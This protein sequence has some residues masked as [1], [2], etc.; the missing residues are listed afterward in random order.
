MDTADT[1]TTEKNVS[2]A[3]SLRALRRHND[4]STAATA[5]SKALKIHPELTAYDLKVLLI[6]TTLVRGI[7]NSDAHEAKKIG[8]RRLKYLRYGP[9]LRT[10]DGVRYASLDE[11]PSQNINDMKGSLGQQDGRLIDALAEFIKEIGNIKIYI[12]SAINDTDFKY[13]GAEIT[14]SKRKKYF[15]QL[16]KQCCFLENFPLP[17]KQTVIS[18]ATNADKVQETIIDEPNSSSVPTVATPNTEVSQATMAEAP[19]SHGWG[20][21]G[22]LRPSYTLRQVQGGIL[23][24]T[25][26]FNSISN[27]TMGNEKKFVAVR[28]DDGVHAGLENVWHSNYITVEDGKTYIIRLYVHNNNPNGLQAIA[29]NVRAAFNLPSESGRQIRVTG[30][31]RSSNATP[32]QYWANVVFCSDIVQFHLEYIWGSA[33]LENRGLGQRTSIK[34]SDDIVTRASTGGILV[35]YDTLD[36]SVPGGYQFATYITIRVKA[37]FEADYRVE[38]RVRLAGTDEWRTNVENVNVGDLIEFRIQYRNISNQTQYDVM[39]RDILPKNLV[40]VPDTTVLVN[41]KE[42]RAFNGDQDKLV[43]SGIDI[44]SYLPGANAYVDFTAKVI[45]VTLQNGSNT[46]VNWSQCGVG[47]V[48]LQDYATVQLYIDK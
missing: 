39:L 20:D 23:G 31:I 35:D 29:K 25:I 10:K 30:Y 12:T 1:N 33:R 32:G 2:L 14:N 44:G 45:D 27:S 4:F 7:K 16:P 17:E 36:G 42:T 26:I 28:E 8:D 18:E 6:K 22:G 11:V 5:V 15:I 48:T 9:Y 13:A 41:A 34:A 19:L 24:D 40:Y 46:L 21:N 47:Q 37:V 3:S 38:Q 43:T